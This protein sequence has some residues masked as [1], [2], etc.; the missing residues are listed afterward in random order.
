MATLYLDRANLSLRHEPGALA[1]YDNGRRVRSVP[2]GLLERVV[3]HGDVA[4][5]SGL[6]ARLAE[7][8]VGVLVLSRRHAARRA[9][10]LGRPHADVCVRLA[11]FRAFEDAPVRLGFARLVVAAKL[12]AQRRLLV[13]ARMR[14]A[15]ARRPLVAAIAALDRIAQGVG[16]AADVVA[17]VGLEGA[18]AA[19]YFPALCCLFPPSLEFHGRNRRPPRDPVNACLSL[20]YTLLHADAAQAAWTVGLDPLLGFLHEPAWGRES[21]AAD[22]VEPLRPHVDEWVWDLFRRRVLRDDHFVRDKGC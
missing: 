13:R 9:Q 18:A 4:L 11:Q 21:L 1:L 5:G 6:L 16:E 15:D 12:A 3:V 20:A 10:L 22:L 2:L 14:R 7:A 8:D 19:A 17:L